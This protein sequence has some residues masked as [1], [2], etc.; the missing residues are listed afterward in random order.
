MFESPQM[1][2]NEHG[3]DLIKNYRVDRHIDFWEIKQIELKRG[4]LLANWILSLTLSLILFG[5]CLIWGVNSVLSFDIQSIPSSH[6]RSYLTFRVIVPWMLCVGGAMWV[7]LSVKRCPVMKIKTEK[8]TCRIA[9]IEFKRANTLEDLI[10]FL[11][12]R[13]ELIRG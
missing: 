2:I 9:L 4:Y 13:V 1:K 6:V 5:S 7:F 8:N 12:D 3:I 10:D 11:S